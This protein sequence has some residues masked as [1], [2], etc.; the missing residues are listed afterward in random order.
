MQRFS[1]FHRYCIRVR[2]DM[3]TLLAI[4]AHISGV[5]TWNSCEPSDS[6]LAHLSIMSP[7]AV[8]IPTVDCRY[9][10]KVSQSILF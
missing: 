10:I 3:A 9:R 1:Y 5:D 2:M 7:Q 8:L 6:I 4:R